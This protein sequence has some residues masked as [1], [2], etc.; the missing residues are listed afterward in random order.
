VFRCSWDSLVRWA[1]SAR[2]GTLLA[3]IRPAPADWT[4][5]AVAA[6]AATTVAA[7]ALPGTGPPSLSACAF[8][9]AERAGKSHPLR[10]HA[11]L[12]DASRY[13]VALEAHHTEREVD[14]VGL[15]VRALRKHGPPDALYLDNGATYRGETLATAC[16][17]IGTSLVHA[18]PYDAPARGKM[19]RFW[20]TL[21]EGC[22]DFL[23]SVSSLHDD[24][25]TGSTT[26]VCG[27]CACRFCLDFSFVA[28][29]GAG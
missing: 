3:C 2:S 27:F 17:R 4:A 5:R 14:M 18:R 1:S 8:R 10:I 7:L 29:G 21:R 28:C 9:G 22:L 23:G 26:V 6:R 19:E 20:R 16:A 24:I 11:L 13:V 12:D 15:M 25:W